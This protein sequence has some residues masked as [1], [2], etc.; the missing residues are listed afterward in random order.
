M[1]DIG[2]DEVP[3]LNQGV[4]DERR[5]S[6]LGEAGRFGVRWPDGE[7]MVSTAEQAGRT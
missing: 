7:E 4:G 6:E 2:M 5:P 1:N 3:V